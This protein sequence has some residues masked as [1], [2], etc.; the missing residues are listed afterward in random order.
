MY[1]LSEILTYDKNKKEEFTFFFFSLLD[2]LM[3]CECTKHLCCASRVF[4]FF[5][6]DVRTLLC[7]L[8]ILRTTSR[9]IFVQ[10][11][12]LKCWCRT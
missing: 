7:Y 9:T 1:S 3:R 10:K 11:K 12:K 8:M 4:L 5:F 6:L 2:L